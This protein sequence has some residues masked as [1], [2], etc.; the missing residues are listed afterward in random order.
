MD[1]EV[2]P[3][4]CACTALSTGKTTIVRSANVL[5]HQNQQSLT[6]QCTDKLER[7]MRISL[8]SFR[9][10]RSL[11]ETICVILDLKELSIS[12]KLYFRNDRLDFIVVC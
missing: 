1:G 8:L 11:K 10:I 4:S 6:I 3:I 9:G 7:N 5:D 2:Y 12:I